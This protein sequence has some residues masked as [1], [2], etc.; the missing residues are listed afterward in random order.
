MYFYINHC[1]CIIVPSIEK[2]Q[3]QNAPIYSPSPSPLLVDTT[4]EV[5]QVLT[6]TV[7]RECDE[8]V[9]LIQSGRVN[10]TP[11]SCHLAHLLWAKH[12]TNNNRYKSVRSKQQY[13]WYST[14]QWFNPN[15]LENSTLAMFCYIP[16]LFWRINISRVV[17]V[18]PSVSR[19]I[20]PV[21]PRNIITGQSSL[22]S[23]HLR[24][25]LFIFT[26]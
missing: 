16:I 15:C 21:P 25:S 4:E 5:E 24:F 13:S 20:Q 19:V 10:D 22:L 6:L 26:L 11:C 9:I 18:D 8:I 7:V 23:S 14:E 17:G 2:G 12:K 3:N 1:T